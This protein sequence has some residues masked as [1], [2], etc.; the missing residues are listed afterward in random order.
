LPLTETFVNPMAKNVNR[1]AKEIRCGN[2]GNV[3]NAPKRRIA[4]FAQDRIGRC[5][6]TN[7]REVCRNRAE[8][9]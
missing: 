3:E 9:E 6:Q 4:A 7:S 5:G 1:T 8:I 2:R